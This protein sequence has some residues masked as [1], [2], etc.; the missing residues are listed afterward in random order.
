MY[1][2]AL[3]NPQKMCLASGEDVY[4]RF[5]RRSDLLHREPLAG[6]EL[7]A[8]EQD[9]RDA[10]A[11]AL[12]GAKN[13]LRPEGV[14]S[15]ARRERDDSVFRVESPRADL[16]RHRILPGVVLVST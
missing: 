11:L 2:S 16:G 3:S 10:R 9:E 15:W 7:D 6:V 1:H 5:R 4:L 14:L 8:A 12:D 13:I